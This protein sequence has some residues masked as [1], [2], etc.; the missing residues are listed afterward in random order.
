MLGPFSSLKHH[1]FS[2]VVDLIPNNVLNQ[3]QLKQLTESP[4]SGVDGK[5][6]GSSPE[7]KAPAAPV[8]PAL[9]QTRSSA[10]IFLLPHLSVASQKVLGPSSRPVRRTRLTGRQGAADRITFSNTPVL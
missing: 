3:K 5:K 10:R 2:R 9:L 1:I 4:G 7:S 8:T 6:S